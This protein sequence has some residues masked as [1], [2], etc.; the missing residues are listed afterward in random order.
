MKKSK[1]L[2][3]TIAVCTVLSVS[4]CAPFWHHGGGGHGG[5]HSEGRG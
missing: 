4:A 3:L 1:L 2:I 5:G